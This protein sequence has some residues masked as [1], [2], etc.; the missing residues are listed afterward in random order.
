MHTYDILYMYDIKYIYACV[1]IYTLSV[2]GYVHTHTYTHTQNHKYTGS[3]KGDVFTIFIV[4]WEV[5]ICVY[6]FYH[7]SLISFVYLWFCVDLQEGLSK[8]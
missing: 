7:R 3:E 2:H 8:I 5:K 1:C 6:S 4:K